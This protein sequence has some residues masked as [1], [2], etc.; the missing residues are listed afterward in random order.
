MSYGTTSKTSE[1]DQMSTP[2]ADDVAALEQLVADA[3]RFQSDT[4]RF[5]ELLTDDYV[6]VNIVGRRV[7]GKSEARAAMEK[8]LDS[9]FSGV[10]TR[11]ELTD[12]AFVRPDV[13]L[14]SCVKH[15]SD[16]R[17]D[18]ACDVPSTARLTFVT[19][20]DGERWRIALA[21][22]TPIKTS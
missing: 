7:Q 8:A 21:Q 2:Q 1:E 22:T 3:E 5:V 12:I 14:V 17:D 6:V 18:A 20:K 19:V 16:E 4:D 10:T 13:A 9:G 15:V 11:H